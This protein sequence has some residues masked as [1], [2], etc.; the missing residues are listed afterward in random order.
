[1]KS[2]AVHAG[3]EGVAASRSVL[4]LVAGLRE[5]RPGAA[6]PDETASVMPALGPPRRFSGFAA[7]G[8]REMM[9]GR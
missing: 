8:N 5:S 2:N 9:I 7:A 3:S 1:V 4:K 6:L